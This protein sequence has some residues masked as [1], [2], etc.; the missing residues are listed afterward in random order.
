M[1][2]IP[3]C[4]YRVS[5][6]AL[7]LDETRTKFLL[8]KEENGGWELPGGGL[9]WQSDPHSELR[10]EIMEEMGLEVVWITEHPSYFLTDV[11]DI[12][13]TPRA[14]VVYEA[15]LSS[16]EFIPSDECMEIRF[17]NREEAKELN[18]HNNVKNF[19]KLFDPERHTP[20]R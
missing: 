19:V 13:E 6:K 1:S 10:R 17:V 12:P 9:E 3:D 4:F 8:V 16:L 7:V 15:V 18:L 14:N 5:V 20:V 11:E 2:N